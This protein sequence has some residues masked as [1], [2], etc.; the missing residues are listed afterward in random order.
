MKLHREAK[1]QSSDHEGRRDESLRMVDRR[2]DRESERGSS[3]TEFLI[4]TFVFGI[5]IAGAL[6][7]MTTQQ[8][9]FKEGANQLATVQS[10]RYGYQAL[11]IDLS[12]LGSNVPT[13]QPSLVLAGEDVIAFT[14]DYRSNLTNDVSALYIDPDAPDEMVQVP[15]KGV[16]L[17]NSAYSWPDTVYEAP[18][19]SP[20]PA[21]LIIFFFDSD[22][23]TARTDDYVLMRQ[24]NHGSPEVLS[25]NIVRQGST[26][27]FRYFLE[28]PYTNRRSGLDSIPDGDLPLFHSAKLHGAAGET[29]NSARSDSIRAV[30]VS[31][32]STNGRMGEDERFTNLSRVIDLPNAGLQAGGRCGKKPI[33]DSDL[34][35][36][37]ETP[38]G[39][40]LVR[41]SWIPTVDESGGEQDVTRYVIYRRGVPN[42]GGWGDPLLSI[43]AGVASYSYDDST[44]RVDSTYQYAHAAQ[45]CTPSLSP[46]SQV[47]QIRVH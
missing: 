6:G 46:L 16:K 9:A 32:R 31:F 44:V 22:T 45:D 18:G 25:R 3:L 17:P 15:G 12:T 29:A 11:E 41:L 21:E 5:V 2:K 30:R 38:A 42:G 43:P 28:R 27:F 13:G 7:F 4:I 35:L 26:P 19:G 36:S 8:N 37:I 33:L 23:T 14:G 40:P 20:S 24:V 1:T 34:T 39:T 10:L 47:Q